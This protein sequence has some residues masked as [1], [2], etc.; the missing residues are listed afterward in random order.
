MLRPT[1]ALAPYPIAHGERKAA[2]GSP[3][4]PGGRP[5]YYRQWRHPGLCKRPDVG[6]NADFNL[7]AIVAPKPRR[8]PAPT[9]GRVGWRHPLPSAAVFRPDRSRL[10]EVTDWLWQH[11][12]LAPRY[13]GEDPN[14]S[15]AYQPRAYEPAAIAGLTAVGSLRAEPACWSWSRSTSS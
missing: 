2:G 9:G 15:D 1:V 13:R 6:T 14:I 7:G 3:D 11:C 4:D 8:V 5:R 10:S 12:D